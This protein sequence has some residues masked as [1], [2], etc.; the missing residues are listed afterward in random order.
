MMYK[1]KT[2][3]MPCCVFAKKLNKQKVPFNLFKNLNISCPFI[4]F[5]VCSFTPKRIYVFWKPCGRC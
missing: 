2:I 3:P 4:D 1:K 5:F